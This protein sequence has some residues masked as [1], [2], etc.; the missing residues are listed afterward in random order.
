M[1]LVA[2]FLQYGRELDPQQGSYYSNMTGYWHADVQPHNLT[3]L[4]ATEQ[5]AP[6]RHLS[7]QLMITANLTEIPEKLGPWNWTRTNKVT[8]NIGDKLVALKPE[9]NGTEERSENWA[10]DVK[11]AKNIAVIHVSPLPPFCYI[12]LMRWALYRGRWNCRIQRTLKSCTWTSRVS[13]SSQVALCM[14]S[15]HH[16]GE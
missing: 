2:A 14:R 9:G 10:K 1:P 4:N 6:W 16:R 5:V 15:P 3:S 13:M 11:E 8:L 7:E 12:P